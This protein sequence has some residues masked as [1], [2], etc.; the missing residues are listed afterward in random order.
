MKKNEKW[1]SILTAM[2]IGIS[3]FSAP[4]QADSVIAGVAVTSSV[5]TVSN[6]FKIE[7]GHGVFYE[8][9]ALVKNKWKNCNGSRYY[10]G[11]DGSAC[12]G[13][14]KVGT[15]VYVFDEQGR[16]LK[17]RK[18]KMVTVF[19]KKYYMATKA[20]NPKTGY[21]VYRKNLYYADSLGRC[22]QNRATEKGKIYFTSNGKAK[23]N[24]DVLLKIETQQVLSKITNSKMSREKKL[25]ACWEYVVD[26]GRFSYGGTDPNLKKKGWYRETA[27]SML[28]TKRGNCFSFACAFAALAKEVGYKNI[29]IKVGYDHCWITING[30]YYDP[31]TQW[32]GWVPG[33]YGLSKHP[34]DPYVLKTYNFMK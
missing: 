22:Y 5:A 18:G 32:S 14:H 19:G 27:L 25:R 29:K 12:T 17:N 21:F 15:K 31:Q 2:F 20:G 33:V 13:G 24:T 3:S 8:K 7:N 34:L 1:L 28:K 16:L 4:V 26:R 6:G 23:K 9:G 11:A 30:K 10:F